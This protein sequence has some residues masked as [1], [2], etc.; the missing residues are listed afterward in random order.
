MVE[1]NTCGSVFLELNSGYRKSQSNHAL[2]YNWA[3]T[4]R[5]LSWPNC[6][7]MT[8][9][10]LYLSVGFRVLGGEM[11]IFQNR[12]LAV[13]RAKIV[14]WEKDP[15]SRAWLATSDSGGVWKVVKL[16][17]ECTDPLKSGRIW[18]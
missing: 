7:V 12:N 6:D 11:V 2:C 17:C 4:V 18:T 10:E 5:A 15:D 14:G 8:P 1:G 3:M 9:D 16:K 13:E